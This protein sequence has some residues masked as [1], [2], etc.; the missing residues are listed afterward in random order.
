MCLTFL[1]DFVILESCLFYVLEVRELSVL[2]CFL[3]FCSGFVLSPLFFDI[4]KEFDSD[5]TLFLC[6][7]V[8]YFGW[9]FRHCEWTDR[10]VCPF[11]SHYCMCGLITSLSFFS[12]ILSVLW[13]CSYLFCFCWLFIYYVDFVVDLF[14]FVETVLR[15]FGLLFGMLVGLR[16]APSLLFSSRIL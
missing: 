3:C 7:S 1:L 9:K 15:V 2:F 5:G 10:G 16:V 14:F 4:F 13:I 12:F 6:L 8:G 11:L